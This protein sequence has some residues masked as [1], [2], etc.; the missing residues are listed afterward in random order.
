M[1]KTDIS[2]GL[3][4]RVLII[5]QFSVN[6]FM[7]GAPRGAECLRDLC[8]HWNE[9]KHQPSDVGINKPYKN[10]YREEYHKWRTTTSKL[11]KSGYL[12]K[13]GC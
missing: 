5:D 10:Y 8:S 1:D 6:E 4:G 2:C 11:T 7:P 13:P 12:W 3:S 9:K